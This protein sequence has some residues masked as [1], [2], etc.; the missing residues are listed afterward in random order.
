MRRAIA[1]L[2]NHITKN[3]PLWPPVIHDPVPVHHSVVAF[4]EVAP[5][6]HHHAAE[7]GGRERDNVRKRQYSA[8]ERIGAA[9]VGAAGAVVLYPA[10]QRLTGLGFPCPL[11]LLTGIPCPFCGM[12]TAAMSL[13]RGDLV[14]AAAANPIVFAVAALVASGLVLL[15]LREGGLVPDP[16]PWSAAARRRCGFVIGGLAAISWVYQLHRLDYY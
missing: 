9:G 1:R 6:C 7:L 2:C 15:A 11:R 3:V 4:S 5:F 13:V 8:P 16:V 10:F 14:G 12:T